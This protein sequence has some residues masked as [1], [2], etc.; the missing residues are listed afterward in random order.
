MSNRKSMIYEKPCIID[1]T[2]ENAHGQAASCWEGS[3]ASCGPGH[4]AGSGACEPGHTATGGNCDPGFS[5][6][7]RCYP[8]AF[9]GAGTQSGQAP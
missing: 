6:Q 1:L 8:G 3:A 2:R 4:A 5:A 7:A 9:P